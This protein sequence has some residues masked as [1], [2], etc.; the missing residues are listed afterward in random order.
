MEREHLYRKMAASG[1][2]QC[3]YTHL[4]GLTRRLTC[5]VTQTIS[6]WSLDS[7]PAPHTGIRNDSNPILK[8]GTPASE[9]MHQYRWEGARKDELTHEL[10]DELTHERSYESWTSVYERLRAFTSVWQE[11]LL[12]A[13][14]GRGMDD[15]FR[16]RR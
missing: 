7:L 1:K 10:M 14:V 16:V 12:Y 4:D 2:H 8:A 15:T 9:I 13:H 11:K 3:L 5:A 6:S